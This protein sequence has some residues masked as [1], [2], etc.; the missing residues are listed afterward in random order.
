MLDTGVIVLDL[1]MPELDG[2]EFA[3]ALRKHEEWRSIPMVVVTAKTL[4]AKER[5]RLEGQVERIFEK[6]RFQR[7]ELL[8]EVRR[9]VDG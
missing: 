3:T 2:F 4:T 8:D 5:T 9:L 7:E 1:L 6:G